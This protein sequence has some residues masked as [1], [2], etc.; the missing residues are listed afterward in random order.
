MIAHSQGLPINHMHKARFAHF[1]DLRQDSSTA[2]C[3]CITHFTSYFTK[4]ASSIMIELISSGLV[5]AQT[6]RTATC[7]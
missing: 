1:L 4:N 6:Q 3:P 2:K 5:H 7:T